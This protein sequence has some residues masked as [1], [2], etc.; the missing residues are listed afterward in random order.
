MFFLKKQKSKKEAPH[1]PA[2]S[3]WG[4]SSDFSAGRAPLRAVKKFSEIY[5]YT[6]RPE[7]SGASW[8]W[9]L[10]P[11]SVK[12]LLAAIEVNS[13]IS[14]DIWYVLIVLKRKHKTQSLLSS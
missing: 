13:A 12:L 6:A 4:A 5:H 3:L 7:E 1:K 10:N 11:I 2:E 14:K 9:I 8:F